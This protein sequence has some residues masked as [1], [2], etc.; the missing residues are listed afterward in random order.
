LRVLSAGVVLRMYPGIEDDGAAVRLR[1]YPTA[2]LAQEQTHDGVLRLA[3]LA[4]PQ[5]HDLVRRTCAADRELTLLAATAG[6]GKGFFEEIADRA[7]A[8]AVAAAD[9]RLPRDSVEFEARIDTGRARVADCGAEVARV[10][11]ATLLALK[12]ARAALAQLGAPAFKA[13]REAVTRQ[14]EARLAPGWVRHT[15]APW[16]VQLPKY[17]RAA[18]RRLER[19]R[20]GVE[21][22]RLLQAQL[23]PYEAALHEIEAAA[24]PERAGVERE[25]LRWMIEEFRVS[26]FA[27]ELRTLLPVSA[28]R[29]DEQVRLAR[30]EAGRA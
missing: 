24:D 28:R 8:D 18:A 29:L 16:F 4:M 19:L 15:P 22:D 20:D 5:Q 12:D 9:G 21:R 6:F 7:V 2:A 25:R 14:L 17:V 13:T 10:A 3:A 30:R 27:Q 26:L 1:L 23:A 11:R